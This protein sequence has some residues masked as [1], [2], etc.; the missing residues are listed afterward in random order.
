MQ[1]SDNRQG[2]GS[3]RTTQGPSTNVSQLDSDK[4]NQAEAKCDKVHRHIE[5]NQINGPPPVKQYT[6]AYYG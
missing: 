4:Q 6:T 5:S 2:R 1:V 3:R